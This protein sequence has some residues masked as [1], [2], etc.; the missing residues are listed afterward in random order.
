MAFF[1]AWLPL[2]SPTIAATF[3]GNS[4]CDWSDTRTVV[5]YM[6]YA[7]IVPTTDILLARCTFVFTKYEGI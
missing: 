4:L 6:S 2:T 3:E 7:I 5:F 1:N